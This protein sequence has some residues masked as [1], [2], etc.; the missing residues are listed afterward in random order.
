MFYYYSVS[1]KE[2]P[3]SLTYVSKIDDFHLSFTAKVYMVFISFISFPQ[4]SVLVS[5]I[6]CY[7]KI[8][9]AIE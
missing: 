9:S 7:D 1:V 6:K 2:G 3:L 4:I 5:K 8:L